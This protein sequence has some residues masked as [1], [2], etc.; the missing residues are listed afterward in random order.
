ME[1]TL[2]L[3]LQKQNKQA[4]R[5]ECDRN[6]LSFEFHN[7]AHCPIFWNESAAF[8]ARNAVD[9]SS[10]LVTNW[11][12]YDRDGMPLRR[13]PIND[14]STMSAANNWH[15]FDDHTTIRAYIVAGYA[16]PDNYNPVRAIKNDPY[17]PTCGKRWAEADNTTGAGSLPSTC[18]GQVLPP[19]DQSQSRMV[20]AI[21]FLEAWVGRYGGG[22]EWK[23]DL[24]FWGSLNL[25]Y[26]A[27]NHGVAFG[28][29]LEAN[30]CLLIDPALFQSG[31][32]LQERDE[33]NGCP[34]VPYDY[35]YRQY[36][37]GSCSPPEIR[38]QYIPMHPPGF[39]AATSADSS[40]G[41]AEGDVNRIGSWRRDYGAVN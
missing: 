9:D 17:D 41:D 20:D 38:Y 28:G 4:F 12:F 7:Q 37:F 27:N 2:Y 35:N 36:K 33:A 32:W 22:D 34:D 3:H 11:F 31:N 10:D 14:R 6:D 16:F 26:P 29:T 13:E 30:L 25:L 19:F 15:H 5:D 8:P 21:H 23:H 1:R 39:G 40:F 18:Y 24:L